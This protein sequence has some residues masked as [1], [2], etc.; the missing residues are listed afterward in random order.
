M[1]KTVNSFYT[2]EELKEIPFQTIGNNVLISRK[3]SIYSPEKMV[4]GNNVRIDDFCV[5]SGRITLGNFIHIAAYCG[6]FA[7]DA[8]IVV[9]DFCGLSSRCAIY[10]ES[11]DYSGYAMTNPMVPKEFTNV[12]GGTVHL[13]KHSI[14]GTGTTILPNVEVGEGVAV[15]SMS[16]VYKKLKPWMLYGGIPCRQIDNRDRRILELE[17]IFKVKILAGEK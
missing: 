13:H 12:T 3:A 2:E 9:D 11:D 1:L 16:L 6:L 15:T 7:G 5:L 14:I 17:Q 8:G 10:A 4:I